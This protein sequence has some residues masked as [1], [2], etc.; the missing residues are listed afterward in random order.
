MNGKG[1][2]PRNCFSKRFKDN[3]EQ[4]KWKKDAPQGGR[5]SDISTCGDG[6]QT[7]DRHPDRGVSPSRMDSSIR[8]TQ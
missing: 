5:S 8:Q 3:Y 7:Y 2:K 1:D 4:I 6:S